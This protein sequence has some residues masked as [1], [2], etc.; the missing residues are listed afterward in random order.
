MKTLFI[1][2]PIDN[3]S[4]AEIEEARATAILEVKKMFKE[5]LQI[6]SEKPV[7]VVSNPS[8]H[9]IKLGESIINLSYAN[10]AYFAEGW[11]EEKGCRVQHS[12]A[13]LYNIPF[14][15]TAKEDN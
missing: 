9:L 4:P 5:E 13:L 3:L 11:Q 8:L 12:C 15:L 10:I 14:V 7:G 2:Q 1:S 6:V